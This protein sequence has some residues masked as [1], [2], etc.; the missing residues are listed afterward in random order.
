MTPNGSKW[1]PRMAIPP[2]QGASHP[3]PPVGGLE[4]LGCPG[5]SP[6]HPQRISQRIPRV[7]APW[8][9]QG[10]PQRVPKGYPWGSPQ[11]SPRNPIS[12]LTIMFSCWVVVEIIWEGAIGP[13]ITKMAPQMSRGWRSAQIL[14]SMHSRQRRRPLWSHLESKGFLRVPGGSW[15]ALWGS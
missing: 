13:R 9:P 12:C 5:G 7:I 8:I 4:D 11:G 1:V 10:I 2:P 6:G 14:S 15:G 3:G